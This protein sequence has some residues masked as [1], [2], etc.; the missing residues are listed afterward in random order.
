MHAINL[1]SPMSILASLGGI[2][3][4]LPSNQHL[5]KC[6]VDLCPAL[7][8]T[9][10]DYMVISMSRAHD[11]CPAECRESSGIANALIPDAI[12]APC[13]E[14]PACNLAIPEL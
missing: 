11:K 7:A 2:S 8:K 13:W 3:D 4:C 6:L 1:K 14:L 9:L 10:S 12:A 5:E